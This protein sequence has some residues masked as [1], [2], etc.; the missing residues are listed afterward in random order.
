ML[1]Y[2]RNQINNFKTLYKRHSYRYNLFTKTLAFNILQKNSLAYTNI[3]I[4]IPYGWELLLLQPKMINFRTKVVYLFSTIYY[5]KIAILAPNLK[6]FYDPQ[7]STLLLQNLYT[8]NFYKL[9]FNQ[10]LNIFYSFCKLF[11]MKLKFKGKGYYIYK[12]SR[13][14][15]TPQFGHSHRIYIYSYFLSV[16]FLTKTTVFLF[17]SSKKD[18]LTISHTIKN[19]KFIN[20]FTGRG[21]RFARQ[22]IYKKTGKVSSYR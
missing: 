11:F 4:Y 8:S 16:K 5:F 3:Y 17:G 10:I 2:G 12:N 14:T 6:W 13:N 9:Y 7:T 21:V 22:I 15:I 19:A 20:I 18:I 1:W